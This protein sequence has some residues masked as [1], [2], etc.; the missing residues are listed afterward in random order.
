MAD[1]DLGDV[2]NPHRHAIL[3]FE[4]DGPQ[5]IQGTHQANAANQVLLGVLR[6]DAA[7]GIGI[8]AS[9]CQIHIGN[10][11]TEMAQAVRID[12]H[13][14]LLGEAT[15]RVDL[16]NARNRAQQRTHDPV[17]SDA[18]L[19]QLF[20]AEHLVA[21][22]RPIQCVLVNLAETRRYRPEH[23][24]DPLRQSRAD[25]E[26]SL[27]HQLAGK[28]DVGLV[29]EDQR[30]QRQPRL[31]Q[32]THFLQ[33]RQAGHRHFQ[34]HGGKALNLLR[35]TPRRFGCDLH[36]NVGDIREGIHGQFLRRVQPEEEKDR[37]DHCDD[38]ALL[39]RRT[40]Q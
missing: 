7:T 14:I 35:R 11:Q 24:R 30:D 3:F 34:R 25:F 27:H 17:L 26:Q 36:L 6:Q 21:I 38:Q 5:I 40:D 4:N 33:A 10:G 18:S 23:W 29:I 31:V 19:H 9:H 15:L 39:K 2:A 22:V 1:L 37:R 12:Q 16:G 28:I 13:L 32:R 20:F 8:V